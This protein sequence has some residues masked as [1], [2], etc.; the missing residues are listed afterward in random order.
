M[1]RWLLIE[2]G[3]VVDGT[4]SA[5]QDA[6]VLIH[7]NL[8]ERVQA[9]LSPEV[10]ADQLLAR[11][12]TLETIDAAGKTVMP[13]LIDAHCHLSFGHPRTQEEQDLYTGVELRTLR[14]AWNAKRVLRAGVTSIS[15]PGSSY[16]IG[17][18]VREA[19]AEGIVEG[20]RVFTAGR[21]ISTSNGIGDY[22]PDAVGVPASSTGAIANT[23]DEMKREVRTQVKNGVDLIKMADS[24]F[25]EFQAFTGDEMKLVA[26]LAH[27]LKRRV[28]IHARGNDEARAA[29]RAGVDWIM[30]ANVI[31]DQTVQELADSKI[32]LVPVLALLANWA[33]FGKYVGVPVELQDTCRRMLELSGDSY[34]RAKAAGVRFGMGS[35]GGFAITPCGEWHARELELLVEYA[36]LTP[37][38][39]IQAATQSVAMTV[40]LEGRIGT[41]APG[42]L[43]DLIVVDGDP[44]RD[45]RVLQ[46]KQKI[47]TVIKDGRIVDFS[48]EERLVL[49]PYEPAQ[50]FQTDL[51]MFDTVYGDPEHRGDGFEPLPWSPDEG[52]EL[53]GD[54]KRQEVAQRGTATYAMGLRE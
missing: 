49:R 1:D 52:R 36:G 45:I 17:V 22:Y 26:D 23:S 46:D 50:I 8:I 6:S 3:R 44:T 28:T 38:E 54:L 19:I 9:E 24:P 21:F 29:V 40:G 42:M 37:L 16:Y 32:L 27:Q 7:N 43:A 47:V 5:P 35:E 11:E 53:A 39:A 13:G 41:I 25:G 33:D 14:T 51:L 15:Q 12:D 34:H 20:P 2:R 4:G 10:V 31:D 48:D 30:H 18:G